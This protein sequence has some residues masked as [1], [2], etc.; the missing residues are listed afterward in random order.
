MV[1]IND[2]EKFK[3]ACEK[4][5]Y[6]EIDGKPCR[7]LPFDKELLGSN[8]QKLTDHNIFVKKI[9]P[10][11]KAPE[12]EELFK[13]YGD[14][15]SLKISLNPDYSSRQYGFVCF[16]TP[17]GAQNA[18]DLTKADSLPV[19]VQRYQ[20][21]DR[22]DLRK[23]FNN[24]YVKNFPPTYSDEELMKLF[25]QYGN[26]LSLHVIKNEKGAFAFVC[27]GDKNNQDREYGPKC[28]M[29]AV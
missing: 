8:K 7:A 11:M 26:V 1:K 27:Y 13:K 12:M 16:Q 6:F 3:R 14:I 2:P 21:K 10:T 9:P 20:P 25:S 28:A 22:R 17:D 15:K 19:E 5:R 24:I 29:R 23:A 4:M 18:I